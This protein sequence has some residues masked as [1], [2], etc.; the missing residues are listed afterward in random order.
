MA[1]KPKHRVLLLLLNAVPRGTVVTSTTSGVEIS[2]HSDDRRIWEM[3]AELP[4]YTY[5]ERIENASNHAW[6]KTK[7]GLGLRGGGAAAKDC[8]HTR[9]CIPSGQ[10]SYTKANCLYFD[11]KTRLLCMNGC[12]SHTYIH[13]HV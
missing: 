7:K 12:V 13:L 10:S 4:E 1:E 5:R 3:T 11:E 9:I 6:Q 2:V 8:N